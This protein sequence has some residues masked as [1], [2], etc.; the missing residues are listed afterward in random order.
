MGADRARIEKWLH[1]VVDA[2]SPTFAEGPALELFEEMLDESRVP[3]FRQYLP[4]EE[5]RYNIIVRVG[6]DLSS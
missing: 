2:Y 4:D 5:D 1:R 6:P 3:Y